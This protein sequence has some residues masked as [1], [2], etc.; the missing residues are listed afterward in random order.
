MSGDRVR[1]P[2]GKRL[3]LFRGG[4]LVGRRLP[5][6]C[7]RLL[8]LGPF[9]VFCLIARVVSGPTLFLSMSA[10]LAASHPYHSQCAYPCSGRGKHPRLSN[11]RIP[12]RQSI[13]LKWAESGST[14]PDRGAQLVNFNS[15]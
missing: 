1:V 14:A 11:L 3:G 12:V 6:G 13:G 7:L 2:F 5:I 10:A 8:C 15:A 9:G 4:I